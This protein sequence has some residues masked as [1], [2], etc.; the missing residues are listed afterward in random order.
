MK[1]LSPFFLFFIS[2]IFNVSAQE[3]K[4]D[5]LFDKESKTFMVLPLITNSPAMQTGFGAMPT[6]FFKLKK[7]D[8][9]SPPSV[10]AL[11]GLYS[12]NKSYVVVPSA[13]LYWNEDKNRASIYGGTMRVNNDFDYTLENNDDIKLVFSELRTFVYFDYSRK[14]IGDFYVGL[15]YFGTQTNYKFDQGTDEENEFTK[16]FFEAND[17]EDNFVSSVGLNLSFDSRDYVYNPSKGFMFTIRPKLNRDWLGSDNDYVDTDFDAAFY[18]SLSLKGILAIGLAGGFAT[19]DVPFDG[20]QNYGVRNSLRG[21]VTGKY[22]GKHMVA[23]QAE[24]RRVIYKRWGGVAFVGTGS[25]WGNEDNGEES[26]ERNWLPSAGLGARFMVS[27]EKKINLRLDF[28]FGVDGNQGLYF[29]IME[30]F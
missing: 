29:G 19:G 9:L 7:E 26:F 17:I 10:I 18:T 3:T 23:L 4:K 21:Y 6:F 22:K 15:L 24:Y 16:E 8:S 20:Y 14:I 2:V 12:T 11:Y 30:A 28:A 5:S 27:R 1:K 13:K 25:I